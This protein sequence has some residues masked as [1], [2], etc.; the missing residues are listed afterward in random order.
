MYLTEEYEAYMK[1]YDVTYKTEMTAMVQ[2]PK[3]GEVPPV[4]V[5]EYGQEQFV[6]QRMTTYISGQV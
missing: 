1:Q 5:S 6:T 2:E 3:V 4:V